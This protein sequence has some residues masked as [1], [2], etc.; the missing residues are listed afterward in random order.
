METVVSLLLGRKN[1]YSK[2]NELFNL[3]IAMKQILA[4]STVM[5]TLLVNMG[6]NS[7]IPLVEVIDTISE[8]ESPIQGFD[9][10]I[11]DMTL[12]A[13][14]V[15]FTMV[16]AVP[17]KVYLDLIKDAGIVLLCQPINR[18]PESILM[19][20]EINRKT[21]KEEKQEKLPAPFRVPKVSL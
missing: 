8:K 9:D 6:N 18:P 19:R 5:C 14:S 17:W 10:T 1:C 11:V 13:S 4:E 3:D 20:E 16:A 15:R 12:S 2:L 7:V 21:I